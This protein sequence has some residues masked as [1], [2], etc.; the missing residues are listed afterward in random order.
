MWYRDGTV[1]LTAGSTAV[2]GTG[3]LWLG[4]VRPGDLITF[5]A[6]HSFQEVGAVASNT[7]L[8]L[9]TPHAGATMAGAPYAI[10]RNFTGTLPARIAADIADLVRSWQLREDQMGQWMAGPADGG[11][12]GD[13]RY[14]LTDPSGVT[15]TVSGLAVISEMADAVVPS[16]EAAVEAAQMA[17]AAA[18]NATAKAA[19]AVSAAGTA[20]TAAGTAA[21]A[22]GT[23]T[24][25]ATTATTKAGEAVT[26]AGTATTKAGEAA[27][28]AA[29]LRLPAIRAADA[30]GI[31]QAKADGSGWE[32]AG[33]PITFKNVVVNGAC[34][35]VQ[36][37]NVTLSGEWRY[38]PVDCWSVIH[39]APGGL[40][41]G[42]VFLAN[43]GELVSWRG[44]GMQLSHASATP[45]GLIWRHRVEALLAARLAGRTIS[46][47]AKLYHNFGVDQEAHLQLSYANATDNFTTTTTLG[48]SPTQSVSSEIFKMLKWEGVEIPIGASAGIELRIRLSHPAISGKMA[49]IGDVQLEEGPAC[50]PVEVRPVAIERVLCRRYYRTGMLSTVAQSASCN[51]LPVG[52]IEDTAEM[53]AVPAIALRHPVSGSATNPIAHNGGAVPGAAVVYAD[54]RVLVHVQATAAIPNY[55]Y[56]TAYTADA[57]L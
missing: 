49:I 39:S 52:F 18:G 13:G 57:R 16:A 33:A 40:T 35:V 11:P 23:A 41:G 46:V 9:A 3:T 50:T 6:G 30:G 32:L 1:S 55:T 53:R 34:Q 8:T 45:Y 12:A 56:R 27:A 24:G 20:T 38:A 51:Y 25:A 14:P 22:A 31:L 2:T 47:Q 19:E 43:T 48:S 4:Q 36:G 29:G 10:I 17:T 28:Y 44:L 54:G 26:A 5:D 7:G 21:T 37:A 42:P 15:R